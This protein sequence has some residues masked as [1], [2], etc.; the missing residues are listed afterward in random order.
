MDMVE[1]LSTADGTSLNYE[2]VELSHLL[3]SHWSYGKLSFDH[4]HILRG[5]WTY[6]V[7]LAGGLGQNKFA[8]RR[9]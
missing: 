1:D 2:M 6:R 8:S 7:P 3:G 5:Y 4:T 9:F